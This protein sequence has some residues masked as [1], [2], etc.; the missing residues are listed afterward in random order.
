LEILKTRHNERLQES[1]MR[2]ACGVDS[3]LPMSG[4]EATAVQTLARPPGIS[5]PPKRLDCGMFTAA[6]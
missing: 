5:A 2:P 1:E 6:F 4:A 3:S